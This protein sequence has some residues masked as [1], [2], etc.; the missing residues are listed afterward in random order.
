MR[1]I[2]LLA[3]TVAVAICCGCGK[4][5]RE[6]R[7]LRERKAIVETVHVCFTRPYTGMERFMPVDAPNNLEF[8]GE[9]HIL[10]YA[11]SSKG[12]QGDGQWEVIYRPAKKARR[13]KWSY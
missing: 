6:A 4:S 1:P 7:F 12:W 5:E 2:V 13:H 10:Q 3:L 9:D 8:P 11:R